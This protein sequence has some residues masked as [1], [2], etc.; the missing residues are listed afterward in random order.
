MIASNVS[1]NPLA[2]F[3]TVNGTQSNATDFSTFSTRAV[4]LQSPEALEQSLLQIAGGNESRAALLKE[5]GENG[6]KSW[7]KDFVLRDRRLSVQNQADQAGDGASFTK[8][9]FIPV[10][11]DLDHP[12]SSDQLTPDGQYA[13]VGDSYLKHLRQERESQSS[14]DTVYSFKTHVKRWGNVHHAS[15]IEL[16]NCFYRKNDDD[17]EPT[18]GAAFGGNLELARRAGAYLNG[19]SELGQ[20]SYYGQFDVSVRIKEPGSATIFRMVPHSEGLEYLNQNNKVRVFDASRGERRYDQLKAEGLHFGQAGAAPLT[21]NIESHGGRSFFTIK[22]SCDYALYKDA[23]NKCDIPFVGAETPVNAAVCCTGENGQMQDTRHLFIAPVAHE[24]WFNV[25]FFVDFSQFS[26][27]RTDVRSDSESYVYVRIDDN[28]AVFSAT[29]IG[30]NNQ[31]HDIG[32]K[33]ISMIGVADPVGYHA[34]FGIANATGNMVVKFRN[35]EL[36]IDAYAYQLMRPV[37]ETPELGRRYPSV[38]GECQPAPQINDEYLKVLE[39]LLKG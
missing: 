37:F 8:F 33:H 35:P 11:D 2:S 15:N 36:K 16:S 6:G 18:V 12:V 31:L 39:G 7:F 22:A 29:R 17:R 4:K 14:S 10:P 24:G 23:E 5:I 3:Q 26:K 9:V 32:D 20:F 13:R 30:N 28:S 21:M 1:A 27:G 19:C 25:K 38:S 34:Q